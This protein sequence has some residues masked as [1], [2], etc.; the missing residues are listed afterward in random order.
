[1]E[2]AVSGY[3]AATVTAVL[4]LGWD[5]APAG[6][7]ELEAAIEY[8]EPML[9]ARHAYQYL[10]R[11][12]AEY[13]A[14]AALACEG[15][16]F[17]Y[18]VLADRARR[19]AVGLRA[20]GIAPNAAVALL[21]PDAPEFVEALFGTW[22]AGNVA[23]PLALETSTLDELS[24]Y[25]WHT[26]IHVLIVSVTHLRAAERAIEHVPSPPKLLVVGGSRG[27]ACYD[28]LVAN[29][30]VW[31]LGEPTAD[32]PILMQYRTTSH[33]GK[34]AGVAFT[35]RQVLAQLHASE[36]FF[37]PGATDR[38]L[39]P[40]ACG[41]SVF[42]ATLMAS[43]RDGTTLV[44]QCGLDPLHTAQRLLTDG[45]TSI[46]ATTQLFRAFLQQRS[47]L[48][49]PAPQL[50][51]LV[52]FGPLDG[53]LLA[54]VQRV[55]KVPVHTFYGPVEAM[56]SAYVSR[57][58][59]HHPRSVG[60]LHGAVQL[61]IKDAN[62]R[63]VD[64]GE[65]GDL[66]I[67]GPSL[68]SVYTGQPEYTASRYPDGW[69]ASGDYGRVD[70]EGRVFIVER[71]EATV[72]R[73]VEHVSLLATE[74]TLLTLPEVVD[75]CAIRGGDAVYD[76][77]LNV[78]VTL[79]ERAPLS[80]P[81][82]H[83]KLSELLPPHRLPDRYAVVAKLPRL[84]TGIISRRMVKMAR[85]R[86]EWIDAPHPAPRGPKARTLDLDTAGRALA[87]RILRKAE[88]RAQ[89][90]AMHDARVGN[91]P[92]LGARFRVDG[93]AFRVALL[94]LSQLEGVRVDPPDPQPG[95]IV[96]ILV[97]NPCICVSAS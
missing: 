39:S 6:G 66:Y 65:L 85:H 78:V 71:T 12:A 45:I 67:K 51:H 91:S 77:T 24:E 74:G 94:A 69:F 48:E 79:S 55:F 25:I 21:L 47:S 93:D 26:N 63:A 27:H 57:A 62:G 83:R 81:E 49:L 15:T 90:R 56:H 19:V 44:M 46:S 22:L 76:E 64:V 33:V 36:R 28:E 9:A 23:V 43:I 53:Q 54:D 34:L 89:H 18:A 52:A 31:R 95:D 73:N 2:L 13:P 92:L 17:S 14:R 88:S 30:G 61:A 40:H 87:E 97:P 41:T 37:S 1:L 50:R 4:L 68:A 32:L 60:K 7:V 10:F 84:P 72:F 86:L 20:Q 96:E 75:V 5:R 59:A 3:G 70:A 11:A 8:P 16:S 82:L 38:V 58:G 35:N 80:I 42:F 29:D